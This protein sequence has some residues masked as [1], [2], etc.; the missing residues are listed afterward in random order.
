[1][2]SRKKKLKKINSLE[3]KKEEHIEKIKTYQG[4]NY[5]LQEYWEKEI[6]AFEAEIEEEKERLKKK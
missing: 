3:K 4:K 2:G 6:R 5:A 1:M